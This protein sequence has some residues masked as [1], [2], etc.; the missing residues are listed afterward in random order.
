MKKS[1]IVGL[2][3]LAGLALFTAGLFMIGNR[4]EAF[5]K[6]FVV[7]TD[8]KNLSGLAKGSKVQV[9]GM[10]A[11]RIDA[12]QIPDSPAA[13][14]RLKIQLNETFR[15]LVRVDSVATVVTEGVVGDTFLQIL[16]GNARAP[17][18][19][20]EGVLQ[21]REPTQ[22]ADLLDQAKGTMSDVDTAVKNANG[23]LLSAGDNLNS[24]LTVARTTIS[25]VDSVVGG[26]KR[27]EG[28][29]GVLLRDPKVA[30]SI[31][32]TVANV[33]VATKDIQSAS[34]QADAL[35]GD[36]RTRDLPQ[37]IDD[38]MESV[39][40]ASKRLDEV[41][42]GVQKTVSD[43]TA[44]DAH[45]NTVGTNM[46]EAISNVAMAS[47][48]FDEDTEAL[49]RNFLLRGFFRRRGYYSLN[50]L[51]TTAY[52][53]DR[54]LTSNKNPRE[55]LDAD[56]LFTLDGHGQSQ[57]TAKGKLLIDQAVAKYGDSIVDSPL[58]VEGYA[59]ASSV[60]VDIELSRARA[61][62]VRN[63]LVERYDLSPVDVGT[64]GLG[65]IPPGNSGRIV[66]NGVCIVMIHSRH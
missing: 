51:S 53:K 61:N 9:A 12:I 18:I 6:H 40:D 64:I 21:S 33:Q 1:V 50:G 26:V 52:R 48:N 27:G 35:I 42:I 44:P 34:A 46:R 41:S 8:F 17:A 36:V 63:Y 38:T 49:K 47:G 30:Q 60:A 2:F 19:G 37:K 43:L 23:L 28:P 15:G 65:K 20:A 14:F 22:L 66:W 10:D 29:V 57:L 31:R 7:Y 24:T 56:Q 59:S 58:M 39:R 13:S 62:A 45:G 4:H 11:G 54:V 32:Q 25:D 3:V 55:W 5:S 16:P